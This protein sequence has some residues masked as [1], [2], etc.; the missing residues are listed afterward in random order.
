MF[1]QDCVLGYFQPVPSGL[2]QAFSGACKALALPA[3]KRVIKV[4]TPGALKRSFPR[5]N[6]EGFHTNPEV[7]SSHAYSS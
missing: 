4:E 3:L 5:M 6:A 1:P 2:M 7:C